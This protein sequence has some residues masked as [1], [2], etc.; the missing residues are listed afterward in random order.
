MCL[1]LKKVK[2]QTEWMK[3]GFVVGS[4]NSNSPKEYSF[5]DNDITSGRYEY[6][7]KQIDND[8][9]FEYSKI[10]EIDVDAPLKFDLSQNYPNPFNP[11]TTIKFSLSVS[12]KVKLPV[13]NILGEEIQILLN[14]TKDAGIHTINF[15]AS[16]LNSEMYFYRL[17]AA[18]FMLVK[19]MTLLK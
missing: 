8:G 14:E 2:C 18:E 7:L 17:Q 12:S 6:R 19:K 10:I 13:F 11:T 3:I 15:S 5:I 16:Q 1:K 4:G 9:T